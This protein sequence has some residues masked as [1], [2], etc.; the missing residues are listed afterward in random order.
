[1][2]TQH[3]ADTTN[4]L[5]EEINRMASI[6]NLADAD[7]EEISMALRDEIAYTDA[8]CEVLAFVPFDDIVAGISHN[9]KLR[10]TKPDN[11]NNLIQYVWRMAKYHTSTAGSRP[12]MADCW[13][14][15]FIEDTTT[16]DITRRDGE[17]DEIKDALELIEMAALIELGHD[18]TRR[19]RRV[20]NVL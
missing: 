1:M 3:Q 12:V 7:K 5:D 19:A 4:G 14:M 11:E 16:L 13:L 10:T 17:F 2:S 18:P 15:T 9:G 6:N 20:Q 8:V